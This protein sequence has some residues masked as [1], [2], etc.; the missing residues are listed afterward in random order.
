MDFGRL[1]A[2]T[3]L[4][5]QKLEGLTARANALIDARRK[6]PVGGSELLADLRQFL[7]PFLW[8]DDGSDGGEYGHVEIAT[9]GAAIESQDTYRAVGLTYTNWLHQDSSLSDV[10]RRI[11]ESDAIERHPLRIVG[12]GGSG[13]TLL[14]QLLAM[15]R[16]MVAR[17]NDSRIRV[18]YLVHNAAMA[19]TVRHRFGVLGLSDDGSGAE[20]WINVTTL[21]DYAR[22]QLG[23]EEDAVIDPDARGA[24]EFQLE[25]VVEALEALLETG[26]SEVENS[27]LFRVVRETRELVPVLAMLIV[28]EIS[29]A[30]KGHGL[31][32]DQKRYV[33]A[34]RRLSRLHGLLGQRER[35]LVFKMFERYHQVVF[36]Q[37]GVLD[38]E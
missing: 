4:S 29:T 17:D 13:K 12:P 11:L 9:D 5:G 37:Y 8:H 36:E 20:Q 23:L 32:R 30:I 6:K 21:T 19:G 27:E 10:Q 7:S 2:A 31:E 26:S 24:K 14:L 33:Q 15:R 18:L 28:S 34:E 35:A 22:N 16:L 1:S 3:A 38:T 25:V